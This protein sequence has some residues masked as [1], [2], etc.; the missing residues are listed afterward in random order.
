MEYLKNLKKP[1]NLIS[2]DC[3]E[4]CGN[5]TYVGHLT[6]NRCI[7]LREKLLDIGAAD[8][9]TIFILNHF[10]HN[11]KNVVYDEFLKIANEN[12]FEVTYDGM[13]IEL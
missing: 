13:I 2:L 6:L 5:A 4:G 8:K 12:N 9:N 11:G 10:S 3:T 1:I 7:E